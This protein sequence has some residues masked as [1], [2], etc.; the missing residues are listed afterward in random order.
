MNFNE[1]YFYK[2]KKCDLNDCYYNTHCYYYHNSEDERRSL[3]DI[4]ELKNIFN[5]KN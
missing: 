2:T 4:D 1:F 3:F 5:S